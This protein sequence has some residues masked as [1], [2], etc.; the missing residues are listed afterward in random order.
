MNAEFYKVKSFSDPNI[1]Y[2]VR[3]LATGEWRCECPAFVFNERKMIKSGLIPK[4]NH[5]R[6]LRHQKL[7]RSKK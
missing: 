4:C 2:T 7:K 1:T 3:R 6:K 5:I